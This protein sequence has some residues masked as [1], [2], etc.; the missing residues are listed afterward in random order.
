MKT[1]ILIEGRGLEELNQFLDDKGLEPDIKYRFN[2]WFLSA[3]IAGVR[4]SGDS[5]S[6]I[7]VLLD[8]YEGRKGKDVTLTI[9]NHQRISFKDKEI[10]IIRQE[11]D[12]IL[13]EIITTR[14]E[15]E[16]VTTRP[17]KEILTSC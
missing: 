4:L 3:E 1:D 11:I 10:A 13:Q 5:E 2:H 9:G 12:T 14:P 16:I 8:Y 17:E 6:L 7:E 15:K